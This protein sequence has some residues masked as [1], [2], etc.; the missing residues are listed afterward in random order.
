MLSAY[1]DETG[2][3]AKGLVIVAGFIGDADAWKKCAAE[4]P[5]GFSGSQRR[6]LHLS[7]WKFKHQTE[8]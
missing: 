6:S 7:K 8:K 5:T 3:E 1:V 4:W 2:Q